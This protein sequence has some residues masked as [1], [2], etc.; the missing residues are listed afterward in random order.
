MNPVDQNHTKKRVRRVLLAALAT[1][2]LAGGAVGAR[3]V[4]AAEPP[5]PIS[6]NVPATNAQA[7]FGDL[8]AKVKPAVVNIATT[9]KVERAEMQQQGPQ[10]FNFPPGSPFAE[11]FRHFGERQNQRRP[12]GQHALG[13]GFIVDPAGYIVTN[14]HV[15]DGAGKVTVTLADGT[16]YPATVKGRDEK[17]DVALLKIDAPKP[18]PY[19]AFGDSSKAREGDWVIAVGNPFGLGGTVTAGI[20][21]AHGRDIHEGPYD[22]FLQIDAPINPGNSGGPLFDQ[23]GHVVGIDTAIYSPTGGSVGIGFAIPSNLAAKVV[24]QLREHGSVERGWLGVAMQPITPALAKAL[25]RPNHDGVVVN[26]VQPDSPA[27]AADLHQG[28]VVTA[29]DGK[30][31]SGPR[32]LAMAVAGLAKGTTTQLTI[33]RDGHER[34]V[35][36]KIGALPSEKTASAEDGQPKNPVGLSLAPLS[37]QARSQL[38]LDDTAKGVVVAN[39]TPDS[40]AAESGLEPGDVIVKVGGD[41]VKTPAEAASRIH[42]AENAKKDAVPLLVTRQGRTYYLA[43]QLAA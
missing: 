11:M 2:V 10:Q 40:R 28:D 13:S 35:E 39:V 24:A 37:N 38:G 32:E 1:T 41:A 43:L 34:T 23:S 16:A 18:L 5:P 30:T 22:D 8:V 42:E 33:W 26:E 36:V 29:V 27:A 14:N 9:A 21:S 7:G 31:V 12:E 25:G 20:I 15:I 4:S 6:E 17:T 3:V 19:V